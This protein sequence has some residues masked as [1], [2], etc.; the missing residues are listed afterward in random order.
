MI[1]ISPVDL[2]LRVSAASVGAC[3]S[4]PNTNAGPYVERVLRRTGNAKGDPWCAAQVTDWGVLALG[5]AWPVR[6]SAS[7]QQIALWARERQCVHPPAE[8][9]VGDLFVLWYPSLN[10]FAHIGIVIGVNANGTIATRE[11]NTS[12]A[13][14]REGWVVAD[15]LRTL[16]TKDRVI[17]WTTALSMP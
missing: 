10:R 2:L 1:T 4:P 14:S 12:G 15:R 5:D 11:G 13:G 6:R 17:R 8:A 3:E 16:G 7:V 9:Q